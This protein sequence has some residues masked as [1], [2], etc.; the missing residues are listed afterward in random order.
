MTSWYRGSGTTG[1]YRERLRREIWDNLSSMSHHIV[2]RASIFVIVFFGWSHLRNFHGGKIR[3]HFWIM[4][5]WDFNANPPPRDTADRA[6]P[7]SGVSLRTTFLCYK[8][9]G[10][11]MLLQWGQGYSDYQLVHSVQAGVGPDWSRAPGVETRNTMDRCP[12][13]GSSIDLIIAWMFIFCRPQHQQLAI[14][15]LTPH[16]LNLPIHWNQTLRFIFRCFYSAMILTVGREWWS[17]HRRSTPG[18][19]LML[20]VGRRPGS[21]ITTVIA[22]YCFVS[23]IVRCHTSSRPIVFTTDTHYPEYQ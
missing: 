15:A 12:G 14:A 17:R 18:N 11:E 10:R 23:A 7:C 16:I 9:Q 13:R 22:L 19:R 1:H 5:R 3:L 4:E 6:G 20:Q 21:F 2:R 8:D